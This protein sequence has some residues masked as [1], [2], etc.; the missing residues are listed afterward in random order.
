MSEPIYETCRHCQDAGPHRVEVMQTGVHY[1][2]VACGSCGRMLR[3]LSKPDS[4]P[5]KYKRPT[6][7]TNLVADYS[8]GYCE[9]CLRKVAEL[10]KGQTLEA[11]HVIEFANGGSNERDNIWIICTA[12]HRIVHWIRT[13]HGADMRVDFTQLVPHE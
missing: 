10:P 6:K 9:M 2:K 5:T 8:R 3:W 12:C 4:D 1:A 11:Q 7:H 13:Y